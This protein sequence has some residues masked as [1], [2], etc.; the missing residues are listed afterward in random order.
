MVAVH[1]AIIGYVRNQLALLEADQS[2][3]V[4]I[5]EFRFQTLQEPTHVHSFE[6]HAVLDPARRALGAE[7]IDQMRLEI[8]ES[9]EQLLRQVD[10]SWLSDP[11]QKEL[12]P[13]LLEVIVRHVN[14]PL[15]QR[16]LITDWLSLPV[17]PV[18]VSGDSLAA[19]SP[20][21]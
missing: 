19:V 21:P 16:V 2:T 8:Q 12:R 6:L 20:Q 13:R 18:A 17:R 4:S 3:S 10:S 1:A 5:G 15:V 11:T 14:E 7:R 9:C